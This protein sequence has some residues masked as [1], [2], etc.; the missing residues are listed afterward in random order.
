[1]PKKN[2]R[3]GRQPMFNMYWMYGLIIVCLLGLYYFQETTR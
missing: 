1:M 3:K 2:N